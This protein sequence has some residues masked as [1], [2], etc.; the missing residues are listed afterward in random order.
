MNPDDFIGDKFVSFFSNMP[1]F[2]IIFFYLILVFIIIYTVCM[3][4]VTLPVIKTKFVEVYGCDE[5]KQ[6]GFNAFGSLGRIGTLASGA[7]AGGMLIFRAFDAFSQYQVGRTAG[8]MPTNPPKGGHIEWGV[9]F[10]G[11]KVEYKASDSTTEKK[12]D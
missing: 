6:R 9:S 11:N 10:G 5:L 3:F 12:K 7:L 1:Q 4:I 2:F 8:R